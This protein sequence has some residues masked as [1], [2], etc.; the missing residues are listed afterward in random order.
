ML[1]VLS[2]DLASRRY[3]DIGVAVLRQL[4]STVEV[5]LIQPHERGLSGEHAAQAVATLCAEVAF[6]AGGRDELPVFGAGGRERRWNRN[7]VY[8]HIGQLG[9]ADRNCRS[10]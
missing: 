9:D 3:R 1:P 5:E 8:M 6:A 10:L 4:E 7:D 2:I